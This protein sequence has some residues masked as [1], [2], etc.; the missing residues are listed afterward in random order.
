MSRL[1]I[2]IGILVGMPAWAAAQDTVANARSAAPASISDDATI[3]DWDLNVVQAKGPP[4]SSWSSTANEWTCLPDRP[5]TP[6][7]DPWCVTD[8]WLNSSQSS[9]QENP[10]AQ[11]ESSIDHHWNTRRDA[12]VGRCPGYRCECPKRGTG[13]HLGRRDHHG[14]G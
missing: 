8:A 6:G 10:G 11:D 3:M 4:A 7:N 13:V 12:R 2:I 5:T 1:L 14:L 9:V